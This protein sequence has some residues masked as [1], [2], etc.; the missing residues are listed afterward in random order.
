MWAF[1]ATEVMFFGGAFLAY[2]IYRYAYHE[3]FAAAS[4]HENWRSAR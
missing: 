3:A 4:S 2:A 1:L